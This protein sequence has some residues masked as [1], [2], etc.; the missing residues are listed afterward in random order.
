MKVHI[1]YSLCWQNQCDDV[2]T[3]PTPYVPES[4]SITWTACRSWVINVVIKWRIA[5][6]EGTIIDHNLWRDRTCYTTIILPA[7]RCSHVVTDC[8]EARHPL[9]RQLRT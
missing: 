6:I 3:C 8:A 5:C 7:L 4:V 2:T 9:R 1:D